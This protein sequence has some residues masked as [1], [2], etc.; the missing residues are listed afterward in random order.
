MEPVLGVMSPTKNPVHPAGRIGANNKPG[1]R[2]VGP[3]QPHSSE[4]RRKRRLRD[5]DS[6]C[7]R[8]KQKYG[9]DRHGNQRYN[10]SLCGKTFAESQAKPLGNMYI[11]VADAK[12]ALRLLVE[13]MSIRA[14]GANHRTRP[15]HDS[16]S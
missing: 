14:H 4:G 13:G 9:K 2:Q 6:L 11:P 15:Q 8:T 5:D 16:A 12:L 10:C 1:F 3:R 7:P